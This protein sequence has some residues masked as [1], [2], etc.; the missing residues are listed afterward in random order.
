MGKQ[1]HKGLNDGNT[2]ENVVI[3]HKL[4]EAV[5]QGKKGKVSKNNKGKQGAERKSRMDDIP[6][7]GRERFLY[8]LCVYNVA[9]MLS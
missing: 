4:T 1:T 6:G 9:L 3:Q 7:K 8:T 2:E 5:M